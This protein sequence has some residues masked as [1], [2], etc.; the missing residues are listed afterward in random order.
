MFSIGDNIK[1]HF[2]QNS[3]FDFFRRS[4]LVSV[5]LLSIGHAPEELGKSNAYVKKTSDFPSLT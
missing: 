1:I 3:K 5:G 4:L 2:F